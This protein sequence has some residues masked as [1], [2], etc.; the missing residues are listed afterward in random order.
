MKPWHEVVIPH[1]DIRAGKFDESVFAADLA[2]VV[3]DRGPLE[4]RDAEI[5]FR[6]TYPTRGLV[7]LLSTVLARL[8]GRGTGEAVIQIQTPFGGGKTHSLIALYH[9][10]TAGQRL[11]D[12][13]LVA[14][15]LTAA[16]VD[17]VPSTRVATF[18]GTAAD[19]LGGKT[20]W[21]T[22][23]EQLGRYDLL[24][25]HDER[26]QAPGKDL[27]HGL[28]Q[29]QPTLILMDEIAEYVVKAKGFSGQV[30][31]FFQE[32][33]ETA[34][35]LPR[36]A[37]VV[38]LP[39]SAP[40]G[41]EGE[42]ALNQLQQIF[43]RVEAIYTPVDGEEIY[44]LIRRRL[45]ED[46]GDPAEARRTADNY[47]ALY[48]RLGD[49]IPREARE[50]AYREKLRMAY[51]FHPELIDLLFERWS[52]FSTFQRT[53]GV[54]RLLAEVVADLYRRQ[55]PTPLIQPAH[56]NLAN[57][58]IRREFLK[59]VGNE[60]EGVIASDI[61]DGNAKAQQIDRQ[62]GGDYARFG[63]ATGLAT[64][65]F[66][67]SFSGSEKK[68]LGI[69]RLRLAVLREGMPVALVGD[70]L[71]RLGEE[72][73]YLHTENGLYAFSN[74]PNLN[75][76]IVEKE[77]HVQDEQIAVAIRTQ[78][79]RLA[80]SELS[81]TL[82]PRQSQD[83]PDTRQLKLVVLAPPQTRQSGPTMAL[84]EELLSRAGAAFR[85]YR[86]TL[87]V[88]APDAGEA[89]A[90]RERVKRSLALRAIQD[91]RAL[92]RQL[93]EESRTGLASKLKD[94]EDSLPFQVLSAYRHLARAGDAGV[95]WLDLGLP[96]VGE[97]GSLAR[98]VREY[99]K[100]QEVLVDRLAPH[101]LVEKAL[102]PDEQEKPLGEIIEAFLRYPHLP[103]LE[104]AAVVTRA[105]AEGV[106]GGLFGL[107]IGERV[108]FRET[109]SDALLGDGA[110]LL[111]REIAEAART[112]EANA[113]VPTVPVKGADRD[114]TPLVVRE[115]STDTIAVSAPAP[116]IAACSVFHLRV[117]VS[118]DKLSDFLRGVVL[119]LH[120]DGA[121][122]EVEITLD[123]RGTPEGIKTSTLEQKVN[124]TLRQIGAT[125]LEERA[126]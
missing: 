38:T 100:S 125:V 108:Y 77:E 3:A 64:A 72:L 22:L 102:R 118:W 27:L 110:V 33:T 45:L 61:V 55:H 62:T 42:R 56:L 19:P 30:L 43:G 99:L 90:L 16:V 95:E 75:R 115:G 94:A 67:G 17:R 70:A 7:E 34:K 91:D 31:A 46:A 32:L 109:V 20:P 41:E 71:G 69:Q 82:W 51:P 79:E 14:Q 101:R 63:V 89:A 86:N 9:L 126:E 53:R 23:A 87:V 74:Q 123:A 58:A 36:C 48:R 37:L 88:L 11:A 111:R 85:T 35:V 52:T 81:V 93:S 13:D 26:R 66:F 24:R 57:T 6:K 92:V 5:F 112:A 1:P 120:S 107:R 97:R 103:M 12:Q 98:R 84:V 80:G 119:P 124:E 25:A 2:D 28:L 59:H 96:T 104:S 83:V 47:V 10:F 21:G 54:L 76:I 116:A 44:A 15:T 4:Y 117:K 60:Y 68:G 122:L 40:Y 50:P 73:W 49:D 18:V 65:I 8:S 39:S 106:V 113:A 105:V 114:E 121:D 29:D 78:L